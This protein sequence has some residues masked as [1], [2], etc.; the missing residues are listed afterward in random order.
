MDYNDFVNDKN[1]WSEADTRRKIID[2]KLRELG[3]RL[4]RM[5]LEF[6]LSD[7]QIDIDNNGK[8]GKRKTADYVIW[9]PSSNMYPI[10]IIE[11][12]KAS[13][14]ASAGFEQAKDYGK[15]L[16]VPFVFSTNGFEVMSYNFNSGKS[17]TFSLDE[18]PTYDELIEEF[19]KTKGF[20]DTQFEEAQ[21]SFDINKNTPRAY[22]IGAINS[23]V[24]GVIQGKKRML[25]VMATGTGKTFVAYQIVK[26]LRDIKK[27]SRVLFLADRTSLISQTMADDFSPLANVSTQIS[28]NID[29]SYE[30][31]FGLYQQL[32]SGDDKRYKEFNK[33]F[34]DLII[35][36]ECHRGSAKEDS[37][38]REILDY[39]SSAIQVGLTATPK[40][41]KDASNINYFG[42]P[43]FSYTLKDGIEDGYL[44]PYSLIEI[45][46]NFHHGF[47]A[48]GKLDIN[49]EKFRQNYYRSGEIGIGSKKKID[50]PKLRELK[51][52]KI[53]EVQ[54]GLGDN[55]KTIV[56]CSDG[57]EAAKMVQCLNNEN[58]DICIERPDY[59][60]RI[61]SEDPTAEID[62]DNFIDPYK[63]DPT[64]AVTS[65]LLSTGVNT[66][67]VE[68]IVIDKHIESMIEFKQI[69]GRG[70]R[71]YQNEDI[72]KYKFLIL[73][74]TDSSKK[75]FDPEFDGEPQMH[76]E[77]G[78]EE[79]VSKAIYE[80]KED[81]KNKKTN[82]FIKQIT[83]EEAFV[84]NITT[85]S[86]SGSRIKTDSITE[87]KEIITGMYA[88]EQV[89][90]D[91]WNNADKKKAVI[92][93]IRKS[94][95][96]PVKLM[97]EVE[98][99]IKTSNIDIFDAILYV[100]Y[101]S[102]PNSKKERTQKVKNGKAYQSLTS[103]QREIINLWLD[104]YL[105]YDIV[106]VEDTNIFTTDPFTNIGNIIEIANKF[107]NPQHFKDIIKELEKD[108]Y[109]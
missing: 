104:K 107:D 34:F 45:R 8:R 13:L 48:E 26:R 9:G 57:E 87:Y 47:D 92:E 19:K 46:T 52:K 6:V 49:N 77:F 95:I 65:Q 99:K 86:L 66:R 96:D 56:F 108:L 3:Y 39:F 28:G 80:P 43:I 36:D 71:V 10:A 62:V 90:K 40:E 68:L 22:Q 20:D 17:Y 4:D 58:S 15:R 21:V 1:K 2:E 72:N 27:V 103:E 18:F 102:S 105:E 59:I 61:M 70:T 55:I 54:R 16:G 83:S 75:F 11:A 35:V 94:G 88:S 29:T 101:E 78:I 31:Y 84:E 97:E 109:V 23:V 76:E 106:E 82:N 64:I 33:D 74:F 37:S 100:A 91:S 30:V 69:I 32:M 38:W 81:K 7:G 93:E 51:A 41:S 14:S 42:E 89:F 44:A 24:D 85:K 73:D 79:D 67:T 53:T 60:K 98:E 50:I 63:V 12:K 25:L 5:S